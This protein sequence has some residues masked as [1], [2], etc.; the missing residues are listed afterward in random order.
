MPAK[1]PGS[2]PS[3]RFAAT[4]VAMQPASKVARPHARNPTNPLTSHAV[5]QPLAHAQVENNMG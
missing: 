2:R 3:N 5:T 1:Q 4:R